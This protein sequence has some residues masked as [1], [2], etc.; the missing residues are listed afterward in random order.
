MGKIIKRKLRLWF[1]FLIAFIVLSSPAITFANETANKWYQSTLAGIVA[2]GLLVFF[3]NEGHRFLERWR[4][5]KSL[6]A[7]IKS[8]IQVSLGNL[9]NSLGT[10]S[11]F[12]H[13]TQEKGRAFDFA[14]PSVIETR[15][16][17]INLNKLG[18]LDQGLL[19]KIVE[20]RSLLAAFYGGLRVMK[21]LV[22]K[23]KEGTFPFELYMTYWNANV[24]VNERLVQLA[25]EI[26]DA[27]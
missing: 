26:A 23:V 3:T 9:E 24:Q 17:D 11:A 14:I 16:L 5:K 2:G 7:S 1:A 4:E 13:T 21:E 25:G 27:I 20:F 18:L 19:V 6:K 10:L 15:I 22:P 8:E 12:R